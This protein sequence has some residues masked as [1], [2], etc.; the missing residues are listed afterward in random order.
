MDI[1][2]DTRIQY[3]RALV[4]GTMRDQM[5][6]L[7]PF[8]PNVESI[9]V[10]ERKEP[11]PGVVELVNLWKAAKTEVPTVAR[12]FIDQSK[13]NWL[14]RA[15]WTASDH[16]CAWSL[17]VGFMPDRVKCGGQTSY[18]EDGPER[19]LIR[20]RGKLE[21]DLKGLLP[22]ILARSATP[23]VE[24]FIVKLV[25]PNFEKTI[26]ALGKYLASRKG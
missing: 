26:E 1:T 24:G 14:D 10:K 21:L 11:A 16:N 5:P 20:M 12:P 17:E 13:L 22:G 15:R 9:E 19:T 25:Q 18:L 8:L 2:V 7:A 4:F 23:T 6:S 3:P